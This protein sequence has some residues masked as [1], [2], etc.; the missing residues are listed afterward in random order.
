MKPKTTIV[1]KT[2]VGLHPYPNSSK[3]E[4]RSFLITRGM[5]EVIN[6]PKQ[7][8]DFKFV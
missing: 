4:V 6:E 7:P 8:T 1:I 2:I 3:N 5:N